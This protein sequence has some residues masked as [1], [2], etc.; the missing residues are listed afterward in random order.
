VEHFR[1]TLLKTGVFTLSRG[2]EEKICQAGV[3][4]ASRHM[5]RKEIM[6][7]SVWMKNGL[8]ITKG[9]LKPCQ[10]KFAFVRKL[11]SVDFSTAKR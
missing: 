7:K 4:M 6:S 8:L 11:L 5:P 3:L 1:N 2:F 9:F 10:V